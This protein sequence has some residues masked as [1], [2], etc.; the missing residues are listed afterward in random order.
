MRTARKR[1]RRVIIFGISTLRRSRKAVGSFVPFADGWRVNLRLLR[2]SGRSGRGRL[3]FGI[4]RRLGRM[5][6]YTSLLLIIRLGC[7]GRMGC[8]RESPLRTRRIVILRLKRGSVVFDLLR[9]SII[10]YVFF[11]SVD[12]GW[13]GGSATAY[14]SHKCLPRNV[15]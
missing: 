11:F 3:V 9:D 12:P 4:L 8:C 6:Q 7:R 2:M 13:T 10:L 5:R 1:S 15:R 14:C